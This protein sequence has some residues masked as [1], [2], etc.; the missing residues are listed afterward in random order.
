MSNLGRI[1]IHNTLSGAAAYLV[2]LVVGLLLA[3]YLLA[4]LGPELFGVWIVLVVT[5]SY[6]SLFDLGVSLGFIKHLAEAETLRRITRRNEIVATGWVFYAG[7]SLL[8][9]GAGTALGGWV[10]QFLKVDPAF[11]PVYWGILSVFGIRNSCVVYRSVLFARQRLDVLNAIAIAAALLNA[12]ATVAVL[13]LGYGLSGLV[14]VSIGVALFHVASEIVMAYRCCDRLQLRPFNASLSTFRTLYHYGIRVQASRLADLVYL[15]VDKLLLSHFVGF[16]S[17]TFYELGAK[18]AG[19]TRTF[20]AVLLQ[21]LLPAAA[22][23]EAQRNR[24][25]LLR[26]YLK[27]SRYLA[28]LAFPVAAFSI[29]EADDVMRLW[30]GAGEH[31]G[32]ALA[33]RALTVAYLFHLLMEAA[34]AV[35]RGIGVVQ[36]EM[37]ALLTAATLNLVLSALLIIRYGLTGVLIG[38]AV[39][40]AVGY[41]LFMWSF[42]RY[43]ALPFV[44]LIKEVYLVPL[45]GVA[46]A[47]AVIA[48]AGLFEVV[49]MSSAASRMNVLMVLGFHGMLFVLIYGAMVWKGGYIAMSDVHLLRRTVLSSS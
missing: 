35:A 31:A 27:S 18:V 47:S 49:G 8:V 43:V 25:R 23:L 4:T 2:D 44:R 34:M 19:V 5:T 30:L 17:V 7:F 32:A 42:H 48:A 29:V 13:A 41:G 1:L 45:A 46:V 12:A 39:S 15:H 10:L 28:A 20:P 36:Y 3:P 26:L 22:E 14:V 38:T 21:G 40:M 11:A 9:I 37:R 24:E 16:G 33:L 6:F